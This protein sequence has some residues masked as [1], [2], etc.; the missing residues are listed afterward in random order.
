MG[1]TDF[2]WEIAAPIESIRFLAGPTEPRPSTAHKETAW[3]LISHL[4]LNYLSLADQ[5]PD[6][7]AV[8]L[9]ELLDLYARLGDPAVGRQVEGVRSII[10]T[11]VPRRLPIAGPVAFGRG[12][13]IVLTLEESAFAGTGPY[14]LGAVLEQFF[15]RYVSINAFTECVL[16]TPSRGEIKRWPPRIGQRH[17]L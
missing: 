5:G 14:L 2:T 12:L 15:A 17:L 8:A 9:R 1:R 13:R 3:K 16:T 11:P 7:G 10:A 4:T 6:E